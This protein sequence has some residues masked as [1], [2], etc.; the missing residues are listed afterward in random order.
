MV[1]LF[2]GDLGA[3]QQRD[4]SQQ[5][6]SRAEPTGFERTQPE[7]G[8]T[9]CTACSKRGPHLRSADLGGRQS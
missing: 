6:D 1:P 5:H 4:P 9:M 2:R 7:T 3:R 8:A